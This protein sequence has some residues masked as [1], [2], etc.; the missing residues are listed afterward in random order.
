M[1]YSLLLR[2]FGSLWF[3]S[4]VCPYLFNIDCLVMDRFAFELSL[5]QVTTPPHLLLSVATHKH[6]VQHL[7]ELF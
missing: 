4:T 1:Y 6:I 3:V 2:L 5:L 7:L